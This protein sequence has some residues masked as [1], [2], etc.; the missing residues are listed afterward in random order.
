MPVAGYAGHLYPWK[1][2]DIFVNALAH[3]SGIRGL[4]VGGHPG[5]PDRARVEALVRRPRA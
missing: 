1:G 2:V 5:E 3:T 4:I